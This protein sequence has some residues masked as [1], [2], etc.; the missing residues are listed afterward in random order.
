M[1]RSGYTDDCDDQWRHIMWRGAVKSAMRGKRG[2]EFLRELLATLDAMPEKRLLAVT[3]N[4]TEGCCAIGSVT[5]ARGI[6]TSDLEILDPDDDYGDS[7]RA[8]AKRIGIAESMAQ[9]IVYMNDEGAWGAETPEQ[10]WTRMREWVAKKIKQA[11][12]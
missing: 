12:P 10:R 4:T 2:Q 6:D 1:S 5:K 7:A 11:T 8:L 9:E 3:I